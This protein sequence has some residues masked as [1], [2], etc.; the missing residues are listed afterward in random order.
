MTQNLFTMLPDIAVTRFFFH[1]KKT[2]FVLRGKKIL[3]Y[4]KKLSSST[5]VTRNPNWSLK[6]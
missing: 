1:K 6:F 2:F 4:E 3:C 5:I